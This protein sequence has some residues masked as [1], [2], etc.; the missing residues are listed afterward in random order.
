MKLE[1]TKKV[2]LEDMPKTINIDNCPVDIS[3]IK[4]LFIHDCNGNIYVCR[5]DKKRFIIE[6]YDN[7][8]Y[9]IFMLR[10]D[11]YENQLVVAK[12][13]FINRRQGNM[14]ELYEILREIQTTHKTG[15]IV[16]ESVLTKEMVSWCIKNG[17][18]KRNGS[19]Y[20]PDSV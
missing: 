20:Q 2:K 11:G 16:M 10:Y 14:S 5:T 4:Q 19:F 3:K 7:D 17:F 18:E 12:V 1:D 9:C 15:K 6:G 13:Q 8:N